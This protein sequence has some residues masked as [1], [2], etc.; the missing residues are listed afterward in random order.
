MQGYLISKQRPSAV[1]KNQCRQ[2]T[3]KKSPGRKPR[4]GGNRPLGSGIES[5]ATESVVTKLAAAASSGL[6]SWA[7]HEKVFEGVTALPALERRATRAARNL[8]I[9]RVGRL[10]AHEAVHGVTG[11]ACEVGNH[12]TLAKL[13][14]NAARNAALGNSR[15]C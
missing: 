7:V 4:P 6:R 3:T 1:D 5:T 12:L 8:P 2:L 9:P 11:R 10:D 14:A 15:R 13:L